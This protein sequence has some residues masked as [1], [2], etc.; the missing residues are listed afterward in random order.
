MAKGL[1]FLD[2]AHRRLK[3]GVDKTARAVAT[4]LGPAGRYVALDQKWG[5]PLITHDGGTVAREIELGDPYENMGAQLLKEAAARTNAIAGDGVTTAVILAQALVGEGLKMVA[6][7]AEPMLL[8]RGLGNAGAVV[9][10]AIKGRAIPI[11]TRAEIANVAA[12]AAQNREIGELIAGVLEQVGPEGAVTIE[13][14]NGLVVEVEHVAGL[15]FDQGYLSP[16]FITHAEAMETVLEEPYLLLY[17][18]RISAAADLVPLLEKLARLSHRNLVVIAPGVDGEALATLV[19]NKLRG[20]LNLVAVKSPGFG[21]DRQALLQDLA[22][23]TGGTLI[24]AETGRRLESVTLADLG[25]CDRIVV[26]KDGTTLFGG[27]G[28]DD[29]LKTRINQIKTEVDLSTNDDNREKLQARLARLAGGVAVIKVGAATGVELR[30]KKQRVEDALRAARAALEA[31]IVPGGGV[32][33]LNAISALDRVSAQ[34]PDEA[35]AVA[36]V[37]R[38]LETPLRFL[39]LNAGQESA[40]IV[41]NVRRQQ[42][43]ENNDC[44]GY[45]VMSDQYEDMMLAGI[46]DPARAVCGALENAISIAAMILTIEVLVADSPARGG[47]IAN[48]RYGA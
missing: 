6:A 24:S 31:G 21:E 32:A 7:G 29:A 15:Q 46:I 34:H 18:R 45:N 47:L 48:A 17:D 25:C 26:T 16:Y 4:T 12:I 10:A 30:E 42:Q 43:V 8:K 1:T 28:A 44:I 37:C 27:H 19:L 14:S 13:E 5:A 38:A 22:I 11:S 40:V 20:S 3:A 2:E 36:I 41:A 33:L 35:A 39:A 9:V 23:L